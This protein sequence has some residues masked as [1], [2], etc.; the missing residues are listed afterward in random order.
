M[1]VRRYLGVDIGG[2]A[3]KVGLVDEEGV[4]IVKSET[5]IDRSCKKENVMQTVTRSMRELAITNDINISS[6]FGIGVSAPGSID[7]VSGAVAK[8]GGNVPNFGGTKVCKI[9]EDEFALPVSVANDG[10][11]VALAEAWIGAAKGSRDVLCVVLGTGIG[12]GIISGG[13]LIQGCKGYAGEIGHFLTHAGG[14]DCA[15]G[16]KGCFEK[17]AATSALVREGS[18]IKEEWTS[19]RIIFAEANAE[20]EEA[21]ALID[22]WTDEVAFG[23]AGLVHIFNPEVVLIGGGVSA[24]ESLVILP[25]RRKV[26]ELIMEDFTENLVVKRASLGNDAGMVGAVKH[27][28][29]EQIVRTVETQPILTGDL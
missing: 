6:L 20:N 2:T 14:R 26:N 12:G 4:V 10:N 22:R 25:I 29:D 27:L 7:M 11:C 15:C 18:E 13:N 9:L 28:M 1:A 19:G 3:V 23:I 8:S 21:L 16:G 5:E 24:Q 17:Y